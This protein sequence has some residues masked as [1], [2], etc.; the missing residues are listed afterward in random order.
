MAEVRFG[1][2]AQAFEL[3]H[4]PRALEVLGDL[5]TGRSPYDR[6]DDDA[7]IGRAIDCLRSVGAVT[8]SPKPPRLAARTVEIT[9]QGRG[10]FERLVEIERMAAQH[11]L[12]AD[13]TAA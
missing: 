6:G 10:L 9:A 11:Q 3:L 5:A 7:V 13:Q 12:G 4:T 2:L 1:A 8:S